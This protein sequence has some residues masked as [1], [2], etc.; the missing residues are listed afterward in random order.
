MWTQIEGPKIVKATHALAKRFH[1]MDAAPSDRPVK[2]RI[3]ESIRRC[4]EEGTFRTCEWASVY[5]KETKKEYRVNG[6]HTSTVLSGMNGQSPHPNV[7]LSRFECDKVEDVARLYS[8]FDTR[9]SVRST[10][11]INRIYAASNPELAHIRS[12][13]ITACVY[14]MSYAMWGEAYQSKLADERAE[15]LLTNVEFVKFVDRLTDVPGRR[16]KVARGFDHIK[17]GPVFAVMFRT[18][19]KS[20]SDSKK[21]WEEVRDE[22]GADPEM[23]TRVLAKWLR[24]VSVRGTNGRGLLGKVKKDTTLPRDMFVKCIHAWNAWRTNSAT[25]LKYYPKADIP[26]IK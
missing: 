1:E 12:G 5:C 26:D 19:E 11:D 7:V 8:T 16:G 3:I 4:V 22:T 14:G 20:K 24:G 18:F 25:D 9:L 21:F 2:P 15:L 6:K 17:R 13:I 10:G 23:P